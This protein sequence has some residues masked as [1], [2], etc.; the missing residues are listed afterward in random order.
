[1]HADIREK[2][3]STCF[4][5]KELLRGV[6]RGT[7]SRSVAADNPPRGSARFLFASD[8][9][10]G[11]KLRSTSAAEFFQSVPGCAAE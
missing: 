9:V 6:E 2:R 7:A 11:K 4:Y 5:I 10:P 1:M 8:K 3:V